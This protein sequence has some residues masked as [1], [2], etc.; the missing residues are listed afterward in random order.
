MGELMCAIDEGREPENS[1]SSAVRTVRLVLAARDSAA[2][3]GAPV[4]LP[5]EGAGR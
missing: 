1:A 2:A 5:P 4:R 3:G